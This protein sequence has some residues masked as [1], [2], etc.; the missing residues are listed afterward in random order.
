MAAL[1][2]HRERKNQRT[3][4]SR[5]SGVCRPQIKILEFCPEV[6][7]HSNKNH[8]I[9]YQACARIWMKFGVK[10]SGAI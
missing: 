8:Q 7:F 1:R 5:L 4:E 6:S 2:D 10:D 3:P 9:L